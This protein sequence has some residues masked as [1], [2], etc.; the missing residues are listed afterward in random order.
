[1]AAPQT[2]K[3][4]TTCSVTDAFAH[5]L[6]THADL[7]KYIE[8]NADLDLAAIRFPN[9]FIAAIRFSLATGTACVGCS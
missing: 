2:I 6:A 1:M 5:F 7:R 8:A 3:P 9:P 4:G